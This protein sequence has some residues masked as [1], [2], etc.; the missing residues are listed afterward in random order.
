MLFLSHAAPQMCR[1]WGGK[2]R[3]WRKIKQTKVACKFG[4]QC[5]FELPHRAFG[6][7]N[8]C[9]SRNSSIGCVWLKDRTKQ[10]IKIKTLQQVEN[11]ALSIYFTDLQLHG[12]HRVEDIKGTKC[13]RNDCTKPLIFII[14][15]WHCDPFV[16]HFFIIIIIHDIIRPLNFSYS[17]LSLNSVADTVMQCKCDTEHSVNKTQSV[18]ACE[19]CWHQV[20]S[21]N[22]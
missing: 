6:P 3:I 19:L 17:N 16:M 8:I 15:S 4:N 7:H 20:L 11:S 10:K 12:N 5:L 9:Q 14:I 2:Q 22:K 18:I 21:W 1:D 13:F